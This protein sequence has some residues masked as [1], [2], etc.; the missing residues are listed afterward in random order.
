MVVYEVDVTGPLPLT[1]CTLVKA[2][3]PEQVASPG[4][5]SRNV[6]VPVG[7]KPP[8]NV[9]VSPTAAPTGP[10]GD[11]TV[12]TVGEACATVTDSPGSLQA[13]AEAMLAASP[14]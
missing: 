7:L 3:E 1:G 9:A 10:L 4:P 13:P 14:E 12:D 5:N 8:A 11:A 2:G 6:T